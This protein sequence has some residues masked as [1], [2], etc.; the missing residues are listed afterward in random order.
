MLVFVKYALDYLSGSFFA[1]DKW[2][3]MTNIIG[4]NVSTLSEGELS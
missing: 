1:L 4:D 3:D 2:E